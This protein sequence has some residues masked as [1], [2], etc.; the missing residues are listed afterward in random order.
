[1]KLV[2]IGNLA[3]RLDLR[4][5]ARHI[6]VDLDVQVLAPLHQ[7]EL[8]DLI[9]QRILVLVTHDLSQL[10]AGQALTLCL[11]HQA[12]PGL[13]HLPARDDISIDLGNNLLNDAHVGRLGQGSN[14]R[15]EDNQPRTHNGQILM[16]LIYQ[17]WPFR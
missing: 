12:R 8:V 6:G 13:L 10:G 3:L 15:Y 9:A 14:R 11:F 7:E 1:M 5:T 4:Q 2:G 17:V 16:V